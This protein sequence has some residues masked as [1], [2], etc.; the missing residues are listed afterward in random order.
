MHGDAERLRNGLVDALAASHPDRPDVI[1]QH[2]FEACATFLRRFSEIYTLNYDLLLYWTVL[3]QELAGL[4]PD[5]FGEPDLKGAPYVEWRLGDEMSARVHYL[6]GALHLFAAESSVRKLSWRRTGDTIKDQIVAQLKED[7]FPLFVAEGTPDGKMTAISR[8]AY[9]ARSY[10][11]FQQKAGDLFLFGCS[12]GTSDEHVVRAIERGHFR[13]LSVGVYG[14]PESD[15]NRV[16]ANRCERIQAWRMQ[17]AR[18][19][20]RSRELDVIYFEAE[21]ATVWG[22]VERR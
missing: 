19:G 1:D 9:L 12:L 7:R 18:R 13:S 14:N 22:A 2:E 6:H 10:R 20:S 16:L 4:F 5:G 21:S 3:G 17:T 15:H 8:N 11:S